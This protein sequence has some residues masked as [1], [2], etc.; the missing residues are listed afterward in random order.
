MTAPLHDIAALD[1]PREVL[2]RRIAAA[3]LAARLDRVPWL[4]AHP[5]WPTGRASEGMAAEY[6]HL[7][8]DADSDSVTRP[9]VDLR[10][11]RKL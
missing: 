10:K 4:I 3:R 9:F 7:L 11:G 2:E 1:V 8:I 5:E 6:R